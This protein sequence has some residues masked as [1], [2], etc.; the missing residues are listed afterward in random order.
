MTDSVPLDSDYCAIA[1]LGDVSGSMASFDTKEFAQSVTNVIRENAEKFEVVFYGAT[2]SDKFSIFADGVNGADVTITEEDLT[3]NGLTALVPAIGRMI[4]YVGSELAAMQVRRPG[5]VIFI[6][7]SD[8]EQTVDHLR[9]RNTGDAP[10]EGKDGKTKL[11][12][13]IDEHQNVWKWSFM[14]MGTN[15]D[16]ISTG[17]SFGLSQKHCINFSNTDGGI[18]QV[19]RCVS[20][21]VSKTQKKAKFRIDTFMVNG[22]MDDDMEED[23]DG[24]DDIQRMESINPSNGSG[25]P[26]RS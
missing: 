14:F 1:F 16:S 10:Y 6:I 19:L 11:K 2:F 13:L 24:F 26:T 4:R 17:A 18:N 22:T 12:E 21:N 25:F 9:N 3:P 7:L 23:D 8:G 20:H 15:F 5:K